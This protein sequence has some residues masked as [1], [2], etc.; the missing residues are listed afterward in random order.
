ML[1]PAHLAI[2]LTLAVAWLSTPSPARAEDERSKAYGEYLEFIAGQRTR[3]DA[4]HHPDANQR[5]HAAS[6]VSEFGAELNETELDRLRSKLKSSKSERDRIIKILRTRKEALAPELLETEIERLTQV[7]LRDAPGTPD[8][9]KPDAETLARLAAKVDWLQAQIAFLEAEIIALRGE[10]SAAESAAASYR[11]LVEL[12]GAR[13]LARDLTDPEGRRR[14]EAAVQILSRRTGEHTL[15]GTRKKL[16]RSLAARTARTFAAEV[17][18]ID[19]QLTALAN[20]YPEIR[21]QLV[22]RRKVYQEEIAALKA[23]HQ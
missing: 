13:H 3:I 23:L 20:D 16:E 1:P 15:E 12:E 6:Q 2:A 11:S 19:Q 22:A 14:A 17:K 7:T 18:A 8:A 21:A 5:A 9:D 4:S 10:P